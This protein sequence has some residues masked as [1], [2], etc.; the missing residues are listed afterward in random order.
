MT[1][2]REQ[3]AK[4]VGVETVPTDEL[5]ANPHNPRTLFDREPHVALKASI[6][7]VGILVP[8]TVYWGSAEKSY[9][10]LDGQRRWICAQELGLKT[11]PVNVVREPDVVQNIVTMFQIHGLRHG[12]ELMPTALKI[13][14]L[15]KELKETNAKRLADLTGLPQAQ[16]V[17][18]Q[19]LLTYPKKYQDMM[20]DPEPSLRPPADFFVELYAIR[21]DPFLNSQSWF[22]KDHFTQ[23]MLKKYQSKQGLKNVTD[24]RKMKQYVT[25]AHKS[26]KGGAVLKRMKEFIEDDTL[27]LE[28]LFLKEVDVSASARKFVARLEQLEKEIKDIDVEAFFGEKKLWDVLESLLH[29]IHSKLRAADRQLKL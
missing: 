20:L 11:V 23:R 22:K 28:H 12:W 18:C 10:I 4:N 25:N 27:P 14:V 26:G 8:L 13:Q 3:V 17:R 2:S 1:S 6:E 24:F 9:V 19:K 5:L 15:M 29:V 7:K 16:V 21:K